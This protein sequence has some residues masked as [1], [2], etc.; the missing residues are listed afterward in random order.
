MN[1]VFQSKLSK[2]NAGSIPKV[3]FVPLLSSTKDEECFRHPGSQKESGTGA[4][5]KQWE[6]SPGETKI[7]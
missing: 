3:P 1:K 4:Q 6:V 5:Q 2:W 7:E